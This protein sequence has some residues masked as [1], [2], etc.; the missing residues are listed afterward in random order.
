M[1]AFYTNK[2]NWFSRQRKR[3]LDQRSHFGNAR[4]QTN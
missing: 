3:P 1:Q 4:N 2:L